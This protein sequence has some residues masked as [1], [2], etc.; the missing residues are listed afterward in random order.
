MDDNKNACEKSFSDEIEPILPI[1]V[2]LSVDAGIDLLSERIAETCESFVTKFLNKLKMLNKLP[3][4][5]N[6]A[7]IVAEWVCGQIGDVVANVVGKEFNEAA[8]GVIDKSI[9]TL[10]DEMSEEVCGLI[11]KGTSKN[12]G[13]GLSAGA[14]VGIVFAV[15]V[16]L[17]LGFL[18]CRCCRG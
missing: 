11:K 8:G 12:G 7:K 13:A 5:R 16:V 15:I 4:L 17:G 3:L 6:L 1:A 14:Y 9:E 18:Y 2:G 10:A